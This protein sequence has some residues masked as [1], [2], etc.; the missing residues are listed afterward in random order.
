MTVGDSLIDV[1]P[2]NKALCVYINFLLLSNKSPPKLS[3]LREKNYGSYSF[4]GSGI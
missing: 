3:N 4:G 1:K 2:D